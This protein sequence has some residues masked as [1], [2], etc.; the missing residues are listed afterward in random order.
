MVVVAPP[1]PEGDLSPFR[2]TFALGPSFIG[3]SGGTVDLPV[4]FSLQL[5]GSYQLLHGPSE[6]RLGVLGTYASLPY[7]TVTTST[8]ESSSFWGA[9]LT[10]D[11]AYRVIE[12]LAL[13]GG[14]GLG[15]IWWAG[16]GA[17]NPFTVK[18]AVVSGGGIP[19]PSLALSLHAHYY[20]TPHL[21]ASLT[22]ELLLSKTTSAGLT[23]AISSVRR[24]DL[25]F[26]VGYRF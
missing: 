14:I 2:A 20:F 8:Q 18:D 3:L 16:L 22:P 10:A 12:P 1:P 19:M 25:D 11:Y 5:G 23:G 7:K 9:L 21:F 6:L 15:V 26:G 4:L 24:F 17:D 13:G